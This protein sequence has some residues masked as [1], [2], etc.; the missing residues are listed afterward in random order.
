M[1]KMICSPLNPFRAVLKIFHL[2]AL[3]ILIFIHFVSET[4]LQVYSE[5]QLQTFKAIHR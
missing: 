4:Q 2:H 5:T 1:T 3:E